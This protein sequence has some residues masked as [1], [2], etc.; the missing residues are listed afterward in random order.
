[1]R[2]EGFTLAVMDIEKMAR[3][4]NAIFDSGL[5]PREMFGSKL[6]Q[7]QFCGLQLLLCPAEVAANSAE[8]NRHQFNIVVKDLDR[9]LERAIETGA[10]TIGEVVEDLGYRS[11]GLYDPDRN[12]MVVKER[13]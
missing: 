6:Y 9:F 10:E 5:Q 4:Y 3:F 12:S 8:Q 1:M 7:G 13:I 11:I 2:I